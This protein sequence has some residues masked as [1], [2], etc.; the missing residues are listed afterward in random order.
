MNN[1]L[2]FQADLG[3]YVVRVFA[4]DE[5]YCVTQDMMIIEVESNKIPNVFTPN[6]DGI[7]DKFLEFLETPHAPK[8]F[9]LMIFSRTNELLYQG[10]KG[11][12]GTYKGKVAPQGTYLYIA[13][14]KMNNG[15]YKTFKGHV[16]IKL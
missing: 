8:D 5:N 3:T 11:W 16:T 12:D 10:N 6:F 4:T 13:R 7:N 15:Q 9:E 2:S 14:R 1:H